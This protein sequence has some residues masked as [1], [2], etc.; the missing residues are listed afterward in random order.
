MSAQ[1]LDNLEHRQPPPTVTVG[2]PQQQARSRK[3]SCRIVASL[4][5]SQLRAT[6]GCHGEGPTSRFH[7]FFKRPLSTTTN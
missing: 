6:R 3:T 7:F 2:H 5:V 1:Q 4:P